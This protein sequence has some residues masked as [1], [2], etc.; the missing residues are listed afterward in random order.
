[1]RHLLSYNLPSVSHP[2]L[3]LQSILTAPE[4][5]ALAAKLDTADDVFVVIRAVR[6]ENETSSVKGN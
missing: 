3:T 5:Q 2:G 6:R 1:M 4:L